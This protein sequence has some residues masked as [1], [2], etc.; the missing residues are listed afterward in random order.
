MS[1][2]IAFFRTKTFS[3]IITLIV[4]ILFLYSIGN[5][6]N[7]VLFTFIFAFLMGRLQTIISTYTDRFVRIN[8]KLILSVIYLAFVAALVY[9]LYKYL[10][11]ITFQITELVKQI[12]HFYQHPPDSEVIHFIINSINSLPINVQRNLL[13]LQ[14]NLGKIYVYVS[15]V[16]A[17][18]LQA[19]I[20]IILSLFLLLEKKKIISFT[21]R[22][23]RGNFS[24]FFIN[25]EHFGKKFINSFG[26]VI[27]VQFLIA[28]TNAVIST[29]VLWM[30]GFPQLIGLGIMIFFLG[31]IPVAGVIVS[32][33]PLSMI[34]YNVNGITTVIAVVVMVLLI[35]GLE[36]YI[37][38]PK[39]MS[40]KTNLPTFFTL[41]ILLF[42]EHFFGIW[43][44]IIGIPVFIFI[45]DM[46]E[47]P[48]EEHDK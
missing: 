18:T 3:R 5:L 39:F 32:L 44:L 34:A 2:L 36:A 22:F 33:I 15:G 1:E 12:I 40:V 8:P 30:L 47:V 6:I 11:V 41:A 19:F 37:L 43:G 38:N 29:I 24:G 46:L 26:K 7:L 23:K 17:I 21:S 9:V 13:N 42:S 35:H 31:L 48:E 14:T 28:T 20:G 27:E 4:L 16:G 25:L 10:P 45:I